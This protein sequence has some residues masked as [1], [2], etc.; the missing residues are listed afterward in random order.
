M[1]LVLISVGKV[2]S[3]GTNIGNSGGGGS[4]CG[5]NVSY[6]FVVVDLQ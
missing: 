5:D 2:W 6:E 3:R 1:F 4:G